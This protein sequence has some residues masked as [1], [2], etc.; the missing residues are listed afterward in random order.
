V[1]LDE[2][3]ELS[4]GTA[5]DQQATAAYPIQ[6][7]E[8]EAQA[9]VDSVL[10]LFRGKLQHRRIGVQADIEQPAV[11]RGDPGRLRQVLINLLGNAMDATPAGKTIRIEARPESDGQVRFSVSDS[12]PGVVAGA[13]EDIFAPFVTTKSR[14]AGLGLYVCRRIVEAHGGRIGYCNSDHG[15]TFWFTLPAG[16]SERSGEDRE[17]SDG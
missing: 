8:I 1:Y 7:Q 17:E 11:V 5:D 16:T 14:S 3:M 12:G 2:L 10:D 4:A 9:L 15:A 6:Q 13:E